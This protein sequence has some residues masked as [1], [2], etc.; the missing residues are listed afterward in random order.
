MVSL[1]CLASFQPFQSC[2]KYSWQV[3]GSELHAHEVIRAVSLQKS[4]Q[5]QF[6]GFWTRSSA[7]VLGFWKVVSSLLYS[8]VERCQ[9]ASCPRLRQVP[10]KVVSFHVEKVEKVEKMEE[11]TRDLSQTDQQDSCYSAAADQTLS[12]S[13]SRAYNNKKREKRNVSSLT[14]LPYKC[15]KRQ[16]TKNNN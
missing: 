1:L 7:G 13:D 5:Q 14:Q 6:W 15:R 8:L 3:C 2:C 4:R 12:P 11:Q 10:D 9:E 16:T